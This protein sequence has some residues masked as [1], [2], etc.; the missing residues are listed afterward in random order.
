MKMRQCHNAPHRSG[1]GGARRLTMMREGRAM[2]VL[3][4]ALGFAVAAT[5]GTAAMAKDW[6]TIK[7]ATEGAFA[8]WNFVEGGK[9][10]GYDVEVAE[11]LCKRM[12]VTCEIAA[13]DWD[14]I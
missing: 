4:I 3:A 14:G 2:R 1:A 8:P 5:C 7:I 9:L 12:Q 10:K 6:K 11:D 13:Q